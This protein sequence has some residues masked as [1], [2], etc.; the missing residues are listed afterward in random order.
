MDVADGPDVGGGAF[1]HIQLEHLNAI[2]GLGIVGDEKFLAWSMVVNTQ[3]VKVS[4]GKRIVHEL[5]VHELAIDRMPPGIVVQEDSAFGC[6][7]LAVES[8]I[9]WS[10]SCSGSSLGLIRSR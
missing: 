2:A 5:N 1:V 3:R 6:I 10:K 9:R 7:V 4:A 8:L